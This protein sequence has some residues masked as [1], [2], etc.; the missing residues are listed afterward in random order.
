[1]PIT[2][3]D[4]GKSLTQAS[5]ASVLNPNISRSLSNKLK[6]KLGSYGVDPT[7]YKSYNSNGRVIGVNESGYKAAQADW[8]RGNAAFDGWTDDD[9]SAFQTWLSSSKMTDRQKMAGQLWYSNQIAQRNA[10]AEA[11]KDREDMLAEIEAYKAGFSNEHIAAAVAQERQ[12]WDSK[13]AETLQS[14]QQQAAAQ[15]R[16]LDNTT[17]AMLR[18]RLEAQAANAIQQ[19]QIEYENKRQEY[20]YNAMSMKNDVYKNTTRTV[21]TQA[22]LASI[23][24]AMAGK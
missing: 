7:S 4:S 20:I 10:N 12:A 13:I 11:K 16:V 8:M 6:Q 21:A 24:S 2:G 18:G 19:T 23:I 14:A 22:D 15:G 3:Y 17:Y 9:I 5:S 1:M